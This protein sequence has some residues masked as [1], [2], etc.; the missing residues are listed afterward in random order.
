MKLLNSLNDEDEN[1]YNDL[2]LVDSLDAAVDELTNYKFNKNEKDIAARTLR[3]ML[4]NPTDGEKEYL[5]RSSYL[6]LMHYIMHNNMDIVNYFEERTKRLTLIVHSDIIIIAMS[7]E[8]LPEEGQHYRNMLKYLSDQG[9]ELIMTEESLME[10]YMQ[11]HIASISYLNDIQHFEN[12]FTLSSVKYI[13]VL[14][15]RA[16]MYN[17]VDGLVESWTQ[18]VNNFC[19]PYNALNKQNRIKAM[20]ELSIY[21]THKFKFKYLSSQELNNKIDTK[22]SG[23]LKEILRP[24]KKKPIMAEHVANVNIYI[25]TLRNN[26]EEVSSNPFG[27]QT[28]WLTREKTVYSIAKDFFDKYQLGSRFIMRPEF[29]MEQIILTPDSKSIAKSYTSTFP[30][31][32]GIQMSQQL[33]VSAFKTIMKKMNEIKSLNEGRAKALLNSVIQVSAEDSSLITQNL[34]VYE[35][36]EVILEDDKSEMHESFKIKLEEIIQ[37]AERQI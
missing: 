16:Y 35:Q 30:T 32:L 27:Y 6:Y 28:Y 29:I 5:T 22:L 37:Q 9:A 31:A 24:Y 7:E 18:F 15:T 4:V 33:S 11:L 13:P 21:L 19:T 34:N 36:E 12:D 26:N 17:K 2:S 1:S 8:Y 10:V 14:M 25:S 20:E 3:S 23:E